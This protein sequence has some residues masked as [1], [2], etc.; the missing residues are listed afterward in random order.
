MLETRAQ[1]VRALGGPRV[2]NLESASGGPAKSTAARRAPPVSTFHTHS[3]MRGSGAL[4]ILAVP[5]L[6]IIRRAC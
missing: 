5:L 3:D 1:M 4:C 6:D 2:L